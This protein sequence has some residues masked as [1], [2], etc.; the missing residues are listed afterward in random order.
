MPSPSFSMPPT[1]CISF[2]VP[3]IAH[4]RASVSG[5]RRY[6]Q[7]SGLPSASVWLGSLANGT[8]MSG[9]SATSGSCQGSEPLAMKPSDSRMTGVR[10]LTAMRTASIAASKQC[11][12]LD[13]ATTG[14]G[15]SPERP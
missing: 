5:S 15:A 6:G 11:T 9:R 8:E 13:A 2:G 10:Y 3:G 1:R 12:G 7:N 4:G 14:S